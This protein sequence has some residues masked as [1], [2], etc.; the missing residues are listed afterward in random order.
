MNT[1][2]L[3]VLVGFIGGVI[4]YRYLLDK[5][6]TLIKTDKVKQKGTVNSDQNVNIDKPKRK[7]FLFFKRRADKQK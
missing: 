1:F 6:D 4:L 7:G 5:P 3:G 2:L